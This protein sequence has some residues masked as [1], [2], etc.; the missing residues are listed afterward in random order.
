MSR[1]DVGDVIANRE[2][3]YMGDFFCGSVTEVHEETYGIAYPGD[4]F[5]QVKKDSALPLR[6]VLNAYIDAP[7]IADRRYLHGNR[8]FVGGM[9][10]VPTYPLQHAHHVCIRLPNERQFTILSDNKILAIHA[11][12]QLEPCPR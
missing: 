1:F 6:D 8:R 11:L 9:V 4:I 10:V 7:I 5:L 2:N 3:P 12:S